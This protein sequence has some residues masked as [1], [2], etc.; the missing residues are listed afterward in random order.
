MD[1]LL[2]ALFL[3]FLVETAS[4]ASWLYQALMEHERGRDGRN[5]AVIAIMVL[6]ACCNAAIGGFGGYFLATMLTPEARNLFLALTLASAGISLLL[7]HK[8][9]NRLRALPFGSLPFGS[10]LAGFAGLFLLGLGGGTVFLIAGIATATAYPALAAIGGAAAIILATL[11]M[12]MAKKALSPNI[13]SVIHRG[14][15]ALLL[16]LALFIGARALSLT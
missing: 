8:T 4:K 9:P 6:A 14:T 1:A 3:C 2:S 7:P 13:L 5:R 15:G 11:V 12:P 16:P 10:L